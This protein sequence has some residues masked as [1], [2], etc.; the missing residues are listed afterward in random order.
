MS[1]E[2]PREPER[3]VVI[4]ARNEEDRIVATIESLEAALPGSRLLVADDGSSDSTAELAARA[5]AELST[6]RQ[7]GK[8]GAVT[9]AVR[10][11]LSDS[12][13]GPE[14]F[15]LCDG[16]LGASAGEL[17]RLVDAVESG[18]CDLAIAA[19]SRRKGGGFG[20]AVGFARRAIRRLTG[21]E[22]RAPISGQRA[23]RRDLVE[24]LLPFAPGFGIETAMTVD[25]ARAGARIAEIEL[26][27]VHR[28]T[29]R[30]AAG[31]LHRGRQLLAFI[32]VYLSRR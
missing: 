11:A 6:S 28:A 4:A 15:V 8:G 3:V 7:Q 2:L 10:H 16:D 21:L 9:A 31:F 5:G 17:R 20:I 29:G 25:A 1:P 22:L 24:K 13:S 18:R 14:T 12:G 30:T 19:F 26:E 27:L 23:L 32:R